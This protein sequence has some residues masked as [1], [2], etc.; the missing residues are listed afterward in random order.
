MTGSCQIQFFF[1]SPRPTHT[2]ER[3][4]RER[5]PD[6]LRAAGG[7]VV[8]RGQPLERARVPAAEAGGEAGRHL[9]SAPPRVRGAGQGEMQKTRKR[10]L[11]DCA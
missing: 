1:P 2:T 3:Q 6:P 4:V 5:G 8:A 7:R 11:L 10:S 9:P